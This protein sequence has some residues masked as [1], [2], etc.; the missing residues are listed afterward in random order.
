MAV[1]VNSE[2]LA[3]IYVLANTTTGW[4]FLGYTQEGARLTDQAFWIDVHGDQYGGTEGPPIE[5]QFLGK[6]TAVRL[7]LTKYDSAVLEEIKIRLQDATGVSGNVGNLMFAGSNCIPLR[8]VYANGG[9]DN[10]PYTV[11]REPIE[12]NKGTKYS[13]AMLEGTAYLPP[14]DSGSPTGGGTSYSGT[15]TTGNVIYFT[16]GYTGPTSGTATLTWTGGSAVVTIT[17]YNS[18]TKE[19]SFSSITG[20]TPTIG[21]AVTITP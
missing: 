1:Q 2:G 17:S 9:I 13:T 7:E 19:L 5:I 11:F 18:G 8:I 14:N 20:G 12:V 21:N 10:C 6:I 16:A 4:E 15:W 3:S